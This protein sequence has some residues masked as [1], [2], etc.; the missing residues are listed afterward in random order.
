MIGVSGDSLRYENDQL[1]VNDEAYDEPY[2]SEFKNDLTDDQLLTEDFDLTSLFGYERVP[3]G[4]LFV[5]GDNR[6]NSK[7]GRT[8]GMIDQKKVL[9]K[10]KFVFW[11]PNQIGTVE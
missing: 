4:K 8:I 11:P 2:L 1:F 3:A 10:V 7:D 9:T 5:L 6:R